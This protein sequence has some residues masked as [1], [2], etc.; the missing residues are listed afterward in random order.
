MLIA[1]S[2][3]VLNLLNMIRTLSL[4]IFFTLSHLDIPFFH[5]SFVDATC[6]KKCF[7]RDKNNNK[8]MQ[9]MLIPFLI[10][11]RKKKNLKIESRN[12]FRL[13]LTLLLGETHNT[14]QVYPHKLRADAAHAQ[15]LLLFTSVLCYNSTAFCFASLCFCLAH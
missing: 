13:H 14:I 2:C 9:K 12:N 4:S 10:R 7:N 8:L 1:F 6:P 5:G 15:V 11:M 3:L